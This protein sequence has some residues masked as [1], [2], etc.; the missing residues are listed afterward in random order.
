[1][2]AVII[3]GAGSCIFLLLPAAMF[4]ANEKWTYGEGVYYAFVTLSTIGF[5]DFIAGVYLFH[6]ITI[7]SVKSTS[8]AKVVETYVT[9]LAWLIKKCNT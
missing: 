1:M 6:Q 4:A 8:D 3:L 9:L 5:G 2:R 7:I